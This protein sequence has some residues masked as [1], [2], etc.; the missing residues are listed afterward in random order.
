VLLRP[1]DIAFICSLLGIRHLVVAVNKMDLVD[2]EE[3]CFEKIATGF[4]AFATGL[5]NASFQQ[6]RSRAV[7]LTTSPSRDTDGHG[8]GVQPLSTTSILSTFRAPRRPAI[9]FPGA[10]GQPS[11]WRVPRLFRTIV[12]GSIAPGEAVLV[13]GSSR[14][15]RLKEIV[16]FEARSI[17]LMRVTRS[18]SP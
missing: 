15:A 13:A 2:F 12:S 6:F 10:M 14:S 17:A 16:T 18:L 4:S 9:P 1:S 8:I 5:R 7:W 3:R 11:E